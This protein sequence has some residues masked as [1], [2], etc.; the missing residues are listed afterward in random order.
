MFLRAIA[1]ILTLSHLLVVVVVGGVVVVVVV[2]DV[3]VDVIAGVGG[4]KILPWTLLP[5]SP[6]LI[7]RQPFL[8]PLF[9]PFPPFFSVPLFFL[10]LLLLFPFL[11]LSDLFL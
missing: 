8:P 2:V 10:S 9:G 7:L 11:L 1:P 5:H 4:K 3:V 6:L